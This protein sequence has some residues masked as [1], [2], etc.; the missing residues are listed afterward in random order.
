MLPLLVG[1]VDAWVKRERVRR[2][3]HPAGIA[4]F[5]LVV[6]PWFLAVTLQ[7]PEFP[8]YA[9]VRETRALSH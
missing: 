1:V 3:F 2:L 8:Y 4:V 7:H 6:G 9:L 5:L